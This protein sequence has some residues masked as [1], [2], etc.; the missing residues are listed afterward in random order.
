MIHTFAIK[1]IS[2]PEQL[3]KR[4]P[5][6][7]RT[8]NDMLVETITRIE[9]RQE[10]QQALIEKVL[11]QQM[12]LP[13][14]PPQPSVSTTQTSEPV[15]KKLRHDM[16]WDVITESDGEVKMDKDKEKDGKS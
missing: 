16:F 3:K 1:V 2:K 8:L 12:I 13:I 7:K 4:P 10:E 6:K 11:N 5:S 14:N 15:P 9:K